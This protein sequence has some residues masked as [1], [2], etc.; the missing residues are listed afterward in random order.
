MQE[1]DNFIDS[2]HCRLCF[3]SENPEDMI[4]PCACDGQNKYVH[5]DCLNAYRIYSN[6]P[7]NFGKCPLCGVDYSFKHV[8]AHSLS[9]LLFKFT[10]KLVFQITFTLSWML[11]LSFIIGDSYLTIYSLIMSI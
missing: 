10:S 6:D 5:R 4:A 8:R 9:Y 1:T 2:K 7:A 11:L 3:S